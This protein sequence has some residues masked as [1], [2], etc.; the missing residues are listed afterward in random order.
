MGNGS[1]EDTKGKVLYIGTEVLFLSKACL[2][3]I[4]NVIRRQAPNISFCI[5][6]LSF[7]VF[8]ELT[9]KITNLTNQTVCVCSGSF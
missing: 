9:N 5:S 6:Q 2:G 8:C 1:D 7:T 3:F 4:P